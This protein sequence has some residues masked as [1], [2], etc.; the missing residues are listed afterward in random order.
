MT[1]LK[2]RR[3]QSSDAAAVAACVCEAYVHYIERI[4]KQPGPMLEDYREVIDQWQVHVA[5]ADNTIVGAIVLKCVDEGFYVD[6]VAVRPP[7]RGQGVGRLLLLLAETEARALGYDS[8][9]LATHELMTENRALYT[10]VGYVEYDQRIV[11][12]YPRVFFRKDL[13]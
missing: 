13:Y 3:A 4:G 12:G 7:V 8:V 1:N 6:N 2:T 10:R 5:E 9:F 11:H